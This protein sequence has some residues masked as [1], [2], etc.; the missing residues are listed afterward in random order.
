MLWD[1]LS[2]HKKPRAA[3]AIE[4]KGAWIMVLPRYS[5]N[6]NPIEMA[7]SK[8]KA[9]LRKGKAR[10]CEAPWKAVGRACNLFSLQEC[11]NFFKATTVF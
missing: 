1:N 2:V 9:H 3:Q 6:F 7:F 8:L 5:P 4:A 10:S 11:W